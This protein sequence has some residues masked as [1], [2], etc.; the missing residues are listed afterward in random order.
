MEHADI[1]NIKKPT[2]LKQALRWLEKAWHIFAITIL[3]GTLLPLM[4]HVEEDGLD[5]V[6]GDPLLRNTQ[7]IIYG[8]SLAILIFYIPKLIK[9]IVAYPWLWGISVWAILSF[10]WS[11]HPDLAFR[12]S[13]AVMLGSLYGL[14]LFLRFKFKEVLKLLFYV[15]LIIILLSYLVILFKPE[16]GLMKAPH[17]GEWRGVFIHKN[18]LAR[19]AL[20]ALLIF[21]YFWEDS[22]GLSRVLLAVLVGLS[23]LLI[24]KATSMTVILVMLILIISFLVILLARHLRRDWPIL[25][26]L[27]TGVLIFGGFFAFME[28]EFLLGLIGKDQTLTGRLPMWGLIIQIAMEKP[29][30]GYGYRTFWLGFNGPSAVVWENFGWHPGH[31]HNGYLDI[32]LQL[33]FVGVI[34]LVIVLSL[35]VRISFLNT[36]LSDKKEFRKRSLLIFLFIIFV[37]FSNVTSTLLVQSGIGDAFFWILFSYFYIYLTTEKGFRLNER[38]LENSGLSEHAHKNL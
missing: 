3:F 33:G 1:I 9:L 32:W 17:L 34:L 5:K 35:M 7:I 36:W 18:G 23:M 15:F 11:S 29:I 26:I 8:I 28:S 2:T 24:L 21:L 14:V 22:R 6:E 12:R 19:N 25:L 20:F 37:V 4:R 31:A 16:W 38:R 27:I 10:I 13:V 30:L